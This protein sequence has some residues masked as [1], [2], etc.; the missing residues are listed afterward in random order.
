MEITI[1][2]GGNAAHAAAGNEAECKRYV[3]LANEAGEKINEDED[4]NI[5]FGDFKSE[6]WYGM[7][8]R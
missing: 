6:P 1:C 4:K 5:F 2:G 8:E 7:M 3:K